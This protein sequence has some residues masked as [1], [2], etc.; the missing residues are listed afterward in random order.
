MSSG[1]SRGRG[2]SNSKDR[3]SAQG[4]GA[5]QP[6]GGVSPR[7]V[8][9]PPPPPKE[10]GSMLVV[11]GGAILATLV[12]AFLAILFLPG[13]VGP[14]SGPTP[15]PTVM[16][17][18]SV[19]SVGPT[20]IETPIDSA[21]P[22][23]RIAFVR[24]DESGLRSL[25]VVNADGTNQ[26]RV[27]DS[28]IVEG[29]IVWTPDGTSVIMQAGVDGV[30]R[31]V[32]V[33]VGPDNKMADSAQLTADV[34]GDSAFPALSPDGKMVAYQFKPK[35]GQFQIYV[36]NIDG[37]NKRMVSDRSGVASLPAWSPDSKSIAYVQ[38]AEQTAGSVKEIW[39]T[40]V[41]AGTPQKI[42]NTGVA[43]TYPTWSPDGKF[44]ASAEVVGE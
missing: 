34:T 14:N 4:A 8:T 44:I 40:D 38:G 43:L 3:Q 20:A 35:D 6:H 41:E 39:T 2:G 36:M 33:G 21:N 1:R 30:S 29:T 31:V 10:G 32:R 24:S 37:S 13:I 16:P 22:Q 12:L 25:Y 27:T 26:Q 15:T 18:G 42:T 17:V 11:W 9:P 7:S 28:I 23:G 19:T 5:Q